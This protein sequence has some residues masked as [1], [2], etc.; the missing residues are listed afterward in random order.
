[1]TT[2]GYSLEFKLIIQKQLVI[3][4]LAYTYINSK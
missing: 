2:L 1:M 3:S 4:S